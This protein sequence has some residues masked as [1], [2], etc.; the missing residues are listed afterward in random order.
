MHNVQA[1]FESYIDTMHH[2]PSVVG[3]DVVLGSVQYEHALACSSGPV[4][5]PVVNGDE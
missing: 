4:S 1:F 2:H 5:S 3:V